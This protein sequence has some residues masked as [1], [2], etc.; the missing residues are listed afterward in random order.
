MSF[1]NGR[2]AEEWAGRHAQRYARLGVALEEQI[3]SLLADLKEK[4][5]IAGFQ[6]HEHNSPA[7][8]DGRDFSVSID[9]AGEVVTR[10]F[11]VTISVASWGLAR[12]RHPLTPQLCFPIGTKP[13]TI[14]RRILEL[15]E[16][17]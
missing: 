15:F 14:T 12:T 8:M 17:S 16:A 5:V 1:K 11:G 7:D 2:A 9:V 6:R 3:A 4:G 10:H 13:E